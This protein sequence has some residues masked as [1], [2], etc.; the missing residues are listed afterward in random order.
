M[1]NAILET[2]KGTIEIELFDEETPNTVKNF[3]SLIE[4][5]FYNGL[6]FHRYIQDFVIQGGDP[7][8]NGSGGPGYQIPCEVDAPKQVHK[9]GALSMAHAGRNTGGSQ[10]FIVLN[11]IN[12]KHLNRNHTVFGQTIK[13]LEVVK[14]LNQGDKIIKA[15]VK[16]ISDKIKNMQL[17]KM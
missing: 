13:G 2:S 4:K 15:T 5:G 7:K 9:V 6:T 8:G 12:C 1:T 3:V 14:Q 16:D 11:E 17:K 10:F